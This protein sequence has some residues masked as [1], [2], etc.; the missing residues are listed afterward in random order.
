[1]KYDEDDEE[2]EKKWTFQGTVM[3]RIVE[4][5]RES[6][7]EDFESFVES[8]E[9]DGSSAEFFK[10]K[11]RRS[12]DT[13]RDVLDLALDTPPPALQFEPETTYKHKLL[14]KF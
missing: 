6:D 3:G 13:P 7:Y 5:Y 9:G 1:M 10:F 2:N 11:V 4:A 14:S 8:L 12:S